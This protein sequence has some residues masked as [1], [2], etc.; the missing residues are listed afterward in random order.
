MSSERKI[1]DIVDLKSSKAAGLSDRKCT[2]QIR[3]VISP[4]SLIR[5]F[6]PI[7]VDGNPCGC[8]LASHA[9]EYEKISMFVEK[10]NKNRNIDNQIQISQ[11]TYH[12]IPDFIFNKVCEEDGDNIFKKYYS[13]LDISSVISDPV[14][15][16]DDSISL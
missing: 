9:Q 14:R 1:E 8:G 15:I 4:E 3:L 16:K 10:Y 12:D 6:S 7:T 13:W 11:F 2:S 5:C